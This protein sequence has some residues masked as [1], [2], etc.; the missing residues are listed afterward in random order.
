[1]APEE[2]AAAVRRFPFVPFRITLTEGSS[3]EVRHRE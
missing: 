3:Y 2:L 1:M